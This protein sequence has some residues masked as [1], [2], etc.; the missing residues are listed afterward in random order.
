MFLGFLGL[1]FVVSSILNPPVENEDE[2]SAYNKCLEANG[3]DIDDDALD[4]QLRSWSNNETVEDSENE[5]SR[6]ARES[7]NKCGHLL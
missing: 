5:I 2:A 1:A 6:Y 3:I 7:L 4:K